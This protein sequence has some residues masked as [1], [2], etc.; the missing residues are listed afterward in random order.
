MN[1]RNIIIFGSGAWGTALAIT[2]SHNVKTVYLYSRHRQIVQEINEQH[3][4]KNKLRN[5][6][7]PVNIIG[8]NCFQK[9]NNIDIAIIAVPV[10]SIRKLL[11][12]NSKRLTIKNFVICSKGIENKNLKF[13][14]QICEEF[15]PNSNI[16]VLSGPNFAQEVAEKKITKTLIASK[17]INLLKNLQ[18]IFDTNFFQ[19]GIS[20]DVR[21]IEIC[22][23]TKNVIAIVLGISKGLKLGANFA[24]TLFIT[25]LME[26]NKL[27]KSFGGDTSTIYSVAGLGDLLLTSYSLKS[28]NTNFGFRF[29]KDKKILDLNQNIVEGYYTAQ[30]IYQ[31]SKL[32]SV[33]LPIF[34]YIYNTLYLQSDVNKI[35]QLIKHESTLT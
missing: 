6:N 2:I 24:A 5:I 1:D 4:N 11:E 18:S 34:Q 10:K 13:P 21:G 8:I 28:R 26:I 30:S 12:H 20:S 31:I 25:S 19:T 7:L 16:A 29:A 35:V 9:I 22:G 27:V 17:N 14:S 32:L 33:D 3:T 15:F 23:A